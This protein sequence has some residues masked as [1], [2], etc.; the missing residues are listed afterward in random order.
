M[1]MSS[2]SYVVEES[3]IDLGFEGHWKYAFYH[4]CHLLF[5]HL[6]STPE[7]SVKE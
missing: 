3:T 7:E 6:L 5:K 2:Q 4:S 1:R